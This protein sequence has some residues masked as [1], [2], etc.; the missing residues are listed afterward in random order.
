METNSDIDRQ[1][2]DF[3]IASK[4][5]IKLKSFY[6]HTFIYITGLI[7]FILKDYY[8]FPLNFF[9]FQYLN[10]IVMLIWSCVFIISAVDIFAY[11]KIFGEEWEQNKVK[12]ILDKRKEK[13][14]WE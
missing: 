8:G 12:N 14:K 1:K 4:K 9:P 7:I 2:F 13:Q 5:V 3:Q 6:V 10:Y 11:Y